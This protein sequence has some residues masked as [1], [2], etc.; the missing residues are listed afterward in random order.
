MIYILILKKI[1]LIKLKKFNFEK[2]NSLFNNLSK[3]KVLI[4]G[5]TIIDQYVFCDALGK[6]GKEPVLVLR[7]IKTEEYLGG[8][9]AISKHL[10]TF[11]KKVSLL[12]MIGEKEEYLNFIKK[13]LSKNIDFKYLKK[14]NS[15][16]ILKRRFLDS[17]SKNKV[18]G[19][20]KINDDK[21]KK[22]EET[23]LN[24]ILNKILSKFDLVIVS[25]YGHGFISKKLL[26]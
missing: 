11:A 5:E 4:I 10:S 20:Y 2:I 13:R 6:S 9:A 26:I 14:E 12:T 15:P 17:V 25:D 24:K 21:I 8:A 18:L 3:T 19:V 1:L 7:D 23:K 16:T 22:N